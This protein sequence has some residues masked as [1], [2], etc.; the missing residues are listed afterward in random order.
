LGLAITKKITD[1]IGGRISFES[2][3]NE[4]SV[5]TVQLPEYLQKT[6]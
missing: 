1:H 5:F 6:F 3:L 2:V 4:G